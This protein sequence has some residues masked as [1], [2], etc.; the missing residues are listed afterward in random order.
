MLDMLEQRDCERKRGA[1]DKKKASI[2][3]GAA[4]V[5]GPPA[6]RFR[7]RSKKSG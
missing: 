2:D 3:V 1:E 4:A 5:A 6:K 7:F